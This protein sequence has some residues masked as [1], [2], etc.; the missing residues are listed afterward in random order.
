M[1]LPFFHISDGQPCH[2]HSEMTQSPV[3]ATKWLKTPINAYLE[4]SVF[5]FYLF[6]KIAFE[7][8]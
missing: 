8:Q 5:F 3:W 6:Q 4:W 7:D 2:D 1:I